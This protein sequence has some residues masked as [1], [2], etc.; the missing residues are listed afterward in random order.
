MHRLRPAGA[1]VDDGEAALAERD[2]A[3]RPKAYG[4]ITS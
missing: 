1:Q 3:R 4:L 2:P